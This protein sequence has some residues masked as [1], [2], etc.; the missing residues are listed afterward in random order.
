MAFGMGKKPE[1]SPHEEAFPVSKLYAWLKGL[2][3]KINK[4]S[5]EFDLVK[6]ESLRKGA[7]SK[8]DLRHINQELLELREQQEKLSQKVDLIIKELKQTA[9]KEELD[10]IKKYLEFWNPLNFV[11]QND[12]ERLFEH[13]WQE[14]VGKVKEGGNKKHKSTHTAMHHHKTAPSKNHSH[15][16]QT[17]H[18]TRKH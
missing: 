2:E 12:L 4:L 3:V 14:F 15:H 9:G 1:T 8:K 11:T 13:K 18:H 16:A 10:V 5:R 17:E 7:Q 6:N